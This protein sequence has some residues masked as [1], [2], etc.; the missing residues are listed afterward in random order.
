MDDDYKEY[1]DPPVKIDSIISTLAY[2][3]SCLAGRLEAR[4]DELD[5]DELARLLTLFGQIASRLGRLLRD[6]YALHGDSYEQFEAVKR[7]M[8]ERIALFSLE[9]RIEHFGRD[10][11]EDIDME[12][13][14][15]NRHV[16]DVDR[17]I[18][19]LND[20]QGRLDYHIDFHDWD[21]SE[22]ASRDR[23]LAVY[24]QNATRLGRLLRDRAVIYGPPPDPLEVM[25]NKALDSVWEKMEAERAQRDEAPD[26][27]P[28]ETPDC[29]ADSL[30]R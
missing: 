24:S 14:I 11:L 26:E 25:K 5:A 6:R 16:V 29:P 10:V 12:K 28:D 1:K 15:T 19:D 18:T 22:A 9:E 3:Q 27:V 30:S 8:A 17:V 4:W 13:P 23:L 21:S 2:Y 7:S 20:V